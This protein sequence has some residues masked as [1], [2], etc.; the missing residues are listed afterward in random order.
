M[1]TVKKVDLY[2]DGGVRGNGRETNVGGFGIVA[3]Y[4]DQPHEEFYRGFRN[5]TNNKMEIQAAIEGLKL[6]L[7]KNYLVEVFSDSAYVV[8]C[9]NQKWYKKWFINGWVTSSKKPVENRELWM[10]LISL[11]EQFP[12]IKFTKVKGHS[13]D[14]WNNL[15]DSLAN[16]AMDEML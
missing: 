12:F 8:N 9:I 14:E 5:T 7:G 11:V 2:V 3:V 10:E 1:T 4:N 15:A 13:T 16:K 6:M